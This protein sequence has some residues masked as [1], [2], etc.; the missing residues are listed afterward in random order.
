MTLTRFPLAARV[1]AFGLA[2]GLTG[3]VQAANIEL[4][5]GSGGDD[6]RSDLLG[7]LGAQELV[8][9]GDTSGQDLVAAARADYARL[10]AALYDRGYYQPRVSILVDGREAAAISAFEEPATVQ[11]IKVDVDPGIQFTFGRTRVAPMPAGQPT[12]EALTSGQIA[13]LGNIKSGAQEAISAWRDQGYAK[14]DIARQ[15]IVADH[16]QAQL[17]V[18]LEVSPGPRVTFGN[19]NISGTTRTREKRVREIAGLPTGQVFDPKAVDK[20]ANRLRR[21]GVFSIVSLTEAEAV[22]E[23]QTLDINAELSERKP[24]RIGL[25]LEY[26]TVEGGRMTTFWMHRNLF[27]G[28]E[29]FRVEGQLAGITGDLEGLDYS[30]KVSLSRP[31]TF[32]PDN[33]LTGTLGYS[34]TDDPAYNAER[35][36]AS[37]EMLRQISDTLEVSYGVGLVGEQVSDAFG[38]REFRMLTLPLSGTLDKRD[39]KLNAKQGYYLKLNATP[40]AGIKGTDS[41]LR[42][43]A[44]ARGY[45]APGAQDRFV[46]AGR[47]QLGSVVGPNTRNAPPDFLFY[48]GGGGTVRG[49]GYQSLGVTQAGGRTSGGLGFIGLS[50]E[51]RVQTTEKLSLVAFYDT[52]FVGDSPTPGQ[53]GKWHSGAGLGVRYNTGLGPIRL[54][55]AAPV[56]GGKSLSGVAFYVGL[57]Q[58]F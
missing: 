37:V 38:S 39:D 41:G 26:D 3:A 7:A 29:R 6:L 34:F 56:S 58:S 36:E 25:G 11:T 48:S 31:G 50:G 5:V 32:H 13:A 18:D 57:G 16:R 45:Y 47:L 49:Q 4:T 40:F 28:A 33:T 12:P 15:S 1:L 42:M 20:S 8:A 51:L 21:T 19:L 43:A 35:V 22:S 53:N 27:G 54:D 30:A 2:I 23:G 46:L 55:V 52:G 17:D 10:L 9:D 24:R 14:A 44:D